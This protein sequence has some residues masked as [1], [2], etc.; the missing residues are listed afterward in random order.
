[1]GLIT[2]EEAEDIQDAEY[3]EISAKDV[4]AEIAARAAGVVDTKPEE[5]NENQ[6]KQ[7]V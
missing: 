3:T 6:S 2:K 7:S 4:L 5:N 1:M